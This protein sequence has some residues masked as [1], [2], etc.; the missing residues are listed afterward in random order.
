[1]KIKYLLFLSFI[2]FAFTS[3]QAQDITQKS[4]DKL[5][6][7]YDKALKDSITADSIYRLELANVDS[8]KTI[9]KDAQKALYDAETKFIDGKDPENITKTFVKTKFKEKEKAFSNY[10]A[11]KKKRDDAENKLN[12]ATTILKDK[13]KLYNEAQS[14]LDNA[15]GQQNANNGDGQTDGNNLSQDQLADYING[16]IMNGEGQ[17]Q[18]A[19]TDTNLNKDE[20]KKDAEDREKQ[21][22]AAE[23]RQMESDLKK[24]QEI[25]KKYINQ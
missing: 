8:I 25:N 1:M 21:K 5:K 23:I 15:H 16:P 11:A 2:F 18:Q 13:Q 20:A 4:V 17:D 7:N 19:P 3:T 10:I 22:E 12:K 9:F 6:G 14:K 24:L